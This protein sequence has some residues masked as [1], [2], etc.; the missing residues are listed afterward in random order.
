MAIVKKNFNT[1]QSQ[2]SIN[3]ND[4]FVG[5]SNTNFG[6]ERKWT[7]GTIIKSIINNTTFKNTGFLFSGNGYQYLPSGIIIQWGNGISAGTNNFPIAFPNNVLTFVAGSYSQWGSWNDV[8]YGRFISKSQYIIHHY[9][10]GNTG[11]QLSWIA[12]GN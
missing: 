12:L 4:N 10:R 1:F 9:Y 7:F 2:T 5:F 11:G 6:G 8:P 3:E